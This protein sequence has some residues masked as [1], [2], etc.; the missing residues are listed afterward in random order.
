[1]INS[2]VEVILQSKVSDSFRC[3]RAAD[4][5][6]IDVAGSDYYYLK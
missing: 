5:L 2:T 4:S 1:M 3:K 6:D